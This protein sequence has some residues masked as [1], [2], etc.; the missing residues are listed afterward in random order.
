[1]PKEKIYP[2]GIKH[3]YSNFLFLTFSCVMDSA[4]AKHLECIKRG[5]MKILHNPVISLYQG[6]S[7]D[8]CQETKVNE[9]V[10][11]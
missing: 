1:M 8:T 7:V 5:I 3:F 10:F 11:S 2:T 6:V 4:E 9:Q